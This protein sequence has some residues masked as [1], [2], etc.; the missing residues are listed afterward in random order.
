[1]CMAGV[2]Q[3]RFENHRCR[4]T[5]LLSF[6]HKHLSLKCHANPSSFILLMLRLMFPC[7]FIHK[8]TF[9]SLCWHIKKKKK[10]LQTCILCDNI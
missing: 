10:K 2:L 8:P 4:E 3:H 6:C 9:V 7:T 1:M 5:K